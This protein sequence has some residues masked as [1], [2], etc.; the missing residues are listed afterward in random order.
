MTGANYTTATEGSKQTAVQMLDT[1]SI[2][3]LI[4]WFL[5]VL[6]STF[7]S[8]SKGERLINLNGNKERTELYNDSDGEDNNGNRQKVWDD[9]KD[10]VKYSYSGSHF[11]FFLATLYVMMT[12]TNWY[13]PTSNLTDFTA[14]EP[15]KWVKIVSSWV[16]VLIYIWTCIAPCILEDRDFF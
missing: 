4:L 11:V 14:N 12:L 2:V 9:E 16:C 7:S 8:A 5:L 6:Y 15:S 3:S 1:P 10:G 13:K